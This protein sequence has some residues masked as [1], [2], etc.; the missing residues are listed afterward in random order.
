MNGLHSQKIAAA[1]LRP[2]NERFLGGL[3]LSCLFHALVVALPLLGERRAGAPVPASA[4][5]DAP[6]AVTLAVRAVA[7]AAGSAAASAAAA[8]AAASA[9]GA[10]PIA[11][12]RIAAPPFAPATP[13]AAAQPIATPASGPDLLP[14]AG[15]AYYPTAQLGKRPQPTMAPALDTPELMPIVAS[16]KLVAVLWIDDGG[17]VARAEVERTDL[18]EAFVHAAIAAFLRTRFL[19]GERDGRPVGSIM[20]I[21][22]SYEDARAAE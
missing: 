1:G 5:G 22:A 20:R 15:P 8:S 17:K 10:P 12:P 6:L 11:V 14:L 3:A 7:P 16:G 13:V 2:E 4:A 18:P 21:E 19:P 9:A